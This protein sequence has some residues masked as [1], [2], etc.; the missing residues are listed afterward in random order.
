M[1]PTAVPAYVAL[2][3]NLGDRAAHLARAVEALRS[4][5]GA[6]LTGLSS[7]YETEPVGGR[8]QGDYLN[9]VLALETTL[10]PQALLDLLLA[11]EARQGRV[12]SGVRNAA[13]TLDLD[14]LLYG[15][16]QVDTPGLV[17]PHPRLHE[18]AFVL[19]P[20]AELAPECVHPILGE[21]VAALA[22]RMSDPTGVRRLEK[23]EVP[24][25]PSSP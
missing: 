10:T 15:D 7:V 22:R 9:A 14:L 13:R 11:V 18:R 12:R 23:Q 17:V 25:W 5:P 21:T 3:S 4:A 24:S 2:G 6:A 1:D 19:A 8:R 16:Q 20:L